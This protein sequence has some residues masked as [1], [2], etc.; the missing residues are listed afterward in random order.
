MTTNLCVKVLIGLLISSVVLGFL[1][2]IIHV[3]Q[4][5]RKSWK[6]STAPDTLKTESQVY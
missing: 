4:S 6:V 3:V 2:V 5:L 1:Y